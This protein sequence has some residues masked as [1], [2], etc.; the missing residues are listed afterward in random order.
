MPPESFLLLII[1]NLIDISCRTCGDIA[2]PLVL[3][4]GIRRSTDF[5]AVYIEFGWEIRR[6]TDCKTIYIEFEWEIRC[7][8]DCKAI[9][10]EF[11]WEKHRPTDCKTIFQF[12]SIL[13]S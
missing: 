11:E 8:T 12:I 3:Q 13:T 5:K 4:R 2:V 1:H 9:Y 6:P 7:P 10:I